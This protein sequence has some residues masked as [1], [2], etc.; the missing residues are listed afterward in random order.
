MKKRILPFLLGSVLL[1]G[2]NIPPGC[3]VPGEC[4]NLAPQFNKVTV[5][6]EL[7]FADSNDTQHAVT[8]QAAKG[9]E[10]NVTIVLPA[11][12]G[13]KD[14]VLVTDESGKLTWTRKVNV[15]RF[16]G[17]ITFMIPDEDK[18]IYQLN[19]QVIED[20]MLAEYIV[21]HNISGFDVNG[22]RITLPNWQGRY[23]G[24]TGGL[25]IDD[26]PGAELNDTNKAHTHQIY[27]I[28]SAGHTTAYDY[29]GSGA[30]Y[31]TTS[32][33]DRTRVTSLDGEDY[34]M[35]ETIAMPLVIIGS[36]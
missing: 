26:T 33:N 8:I 27:T 18:G 7:H 35:P 6:E 11:S 31:F 28:D 36:K 14:Q 16:L 22:S 12:N 20:E 32:T 25:G 15:N 10:E 13:Q 1:V 34:F 23:V 3:E 29:A 2:A 5:A 30:T 24:A 4:P 21:E 17:M 9:M 19:G